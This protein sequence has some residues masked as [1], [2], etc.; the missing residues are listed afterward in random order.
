MTL[1]YYKFKFN[2]LRADVKPFWP[3]T[4]FNRA[5]YKPL[6][7]L[8]IMD[9]MAQ[10]VIDANLIKFNADLI[11]AFDLYWAKIIGS[12]RDSNPVMPFNYLRSEGF[13]YLT[14]IQGVE[15]NLNNTDRN[16]VFRRIKNQD[17][18]ARLDLTFR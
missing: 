10:Q 13:W 12:T 8:A 2:K 17:L 15:P 3:A 4:T 5:P 1:D 9:L 11:D 18:V 7:L 14:T 16:N 6:L